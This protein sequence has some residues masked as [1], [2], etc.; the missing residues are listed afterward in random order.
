MKRDYWLLL[1]WARHLK[2]MQQQ[3]DDA[4]AQR[5]RLNREN[6]ELVEKLEL[7]K[8]YADVFAVENG[9]MKAQLLDIMHT[10]DRL[11][12][13]NVDLQKRIDHATNTARPTTKRIVRAKKED[14]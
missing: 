5:D 14:V 11:T 4:R 6:A 13:E 8:S 1:P 12:A 9:T 3:R 10:V 7:Q 2:Q